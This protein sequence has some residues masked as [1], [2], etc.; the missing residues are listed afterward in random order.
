MEI[1]IVVPVYNEIDN[2][3]LLVTAICHAVEQSDV[4][5]WELLAVDDGSTDGSR[6]LLDILQE[7]CPNLRPLKFQSNQGQTAAMDAGF[8]HARYPYVLALDADLQNDPGDLPILLAAIAP[9][10]GCVAGVR[11]QR[12]D[13]WVRIWSSKVANWIRNRLT[14]EDIADT[15]CSL[16]LF[17][18]SCLDEIKL[19]EGMHRFLP[20]LIHLTGYEVVQVPVS[21]KPRFAGVSKYGIANRALRSFVDLLAVRW[22]KKRWLRYALVEDVAPVA[23]V[24][25][26]C[27]LR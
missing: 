23:V 22:M 24:A 27:E 15:G 13:T 9:E 6:E 10:V 12:Q 19:Y 8:R 21:H 5:S 1:S 16:K 3:R 25:N 17:R 11:T 20:T 4:S 7:D 2:L 18:K 26:E 14:D